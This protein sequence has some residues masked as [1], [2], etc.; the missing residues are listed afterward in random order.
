MGYRTG[1]LGSSA[2]PLAASRRA[3]AFTHRALVVELLF[4]EWQTGR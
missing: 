2:P 3:L 4:C 1:R